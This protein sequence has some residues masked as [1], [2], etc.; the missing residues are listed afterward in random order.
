VCSSDLVL[1]TIDAD[2]PVIVKGTMKYNP[3]R[4]EATDVYVG[5]SVPGVGSDAVVGNIISRSENTLRV[6]GVIYTK[7]YGVTNLN[8]T[9][10]VT[11]SS[12]T[13]VTKQKADGTFSIDDLAPGQRVAVYGDLSYTEASTPSFDATAGKVDMLMTRLRGHVISTD[14]MIPQMNI[15]LG[16]I[17][18]RDVSLFDFTGT[19]TSVE[20]DADPMNYEIFTGNLGLSAFNADDPI[21]VY[22]FTNAFGQAPYDF[23]ATTLVNYDSLPTVVSLKWAPA[24]TSPF[25]S[26]TD[27]QLVVNLTG[28]HLFPLF[29]KSGF[30]H[31]LENTVTSATI[32]P[33]NTGTFIIVMKRNTKVYTTFA[34]FTAKLS[35]LLDGN[36]AAKRLFGSGVYDNASHTFTATYLSIE[37]K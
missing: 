26:I 34:D 13:L 11:L 31:L 20:N 35:T 36:N 22:G 5:N 33:D 2:T 21:M 12:D 25:T 9:A 24:T 4:F 1:S 30:D 32:V 29:C 19:G 8:D 17:D 27:T 23:S 18:M 7:D 37:L 14:T 28:S 16:T 6:N 10:I 15:N 3:R